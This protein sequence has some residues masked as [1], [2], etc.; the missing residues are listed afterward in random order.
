MGWSV[1]HAVAIGPSTWHQGPQ[2][3]RRGGTRGRGLDVEPSG[4][5]SSEAW[6]A[7]LAAGLLVVA[8]ALLR[9]T[10][11]PWLGDRAPFATYYPAVAVAA[12]LPGLGPG[13]LATGASAGVVLASWAAIP[14]QSPLS[15]HHLVSLGAFA[16]SGAL[17]TVLAGRLR[18]TRRTGRRLRRLATR[19]GAASAGPGA[20]AGAGDEA[21]VIPPAAPAASVTAALRDNTAAGGSTDESRESRRGED[22]FFSVVS[23]EL[24]SPLNAILGWSYVLERQLGGQEDARASLAV[25]QRNAR[26]QA[27]IISDLLDLRALSRG[28]PSPMEVTDLVPLVTE[29]VLRQQDEAAAKSVALRA[30]VPDAPV[31]VVGNPPRLQQAIANLAANAVKFTPGGG[32]VDVE[33]EGDATHA[34][35]RVRD[36]GEG[37][38]REFL[39]YVFDRF[40]QGDGGRARQYQGL[41]I[42]LALVREIAEA[43]DGTVEAESAGRGRGASFTL[44]LPAAPQAEPREPRRAP[45]PPPA[46]LSSLRVLVVDDDADARGFVTQVLRGAQAETDTASSASEAIDRWAELRPDVLVSDIGMPG[47][48]GFALIRSIR[49]LDPARGGEVPAVALTAY[50]DEASRREAAQ[51]GFDALESKP[52]DAAHLVSVV[53]RLASRGKRHAG[54][55]AR[56]P[57]M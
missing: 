13:L 34:T 24:R 8:A 22:E 7:H 26:A 45:A 11:Q 30:V 50:D 57:E 21:G 2:G 23:H 1:L 52:V 27:R 9:L 33:L 39:P 31:L 19:R 53:A 51:A 17:M 41:G 29:A 44:R 35:V 28:V 5:S 46:D 42:G 56:R 36:D 48:D 32:H 40:R 15:T 6:L 43:H 49:A 18:E 10:L 25:I 14:G 4:R 47:Q 38:D 16:L 54:A 37:I 55:P 3:R 20:T 12:F